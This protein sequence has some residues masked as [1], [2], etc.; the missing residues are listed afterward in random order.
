M[1]STSL[2]IPQ[3]VHALNYGFD[4]CG[5]VVLTINVC[6]EMKGFIDPADGGTGTCS[7]AGNPYT[8]SYWEEWTSKPYTG[9][10]VFQPEGT[11]AFGFDLKA[12]S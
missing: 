3:R 1:P 10:L 2:P 7:I 11:N 8:V 5:V 12:L 9:T 4:R 6:I